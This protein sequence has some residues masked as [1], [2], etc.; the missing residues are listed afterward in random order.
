MRKS[1]RGKRGGA[2]DESWEEKEAED[3][4]PPASP[5]G[6]PSLPSNEAELTK[7][8]DA[9]AAPSGQE[10]Q[11]QII[12]M[13]DGCLEGGEEEDEEKEGLK[14]VNIKGE[15]K[16][17][18][19]DCV[20]SVIYVFVLPPIFPCVLQLR[21]NRGGSLPDLKRNDVALHHRIHLL[22]PNCPRLDPTTLWVRHTHTHTLQQ[23]GMCFRLKKREV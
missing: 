20:H 6:P 12:G 1:T 13:V 18:D 15:E 16:N 19:C 5:L 17:E 10:V 7:Q 3:D 4:E 21:A 14:R 22:N 23:P 2:S 8:V 9:N 11:L